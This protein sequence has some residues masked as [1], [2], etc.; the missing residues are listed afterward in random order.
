MAPQVFATRQVAVT[1]KDYESLGTSFASPLSGKVAVAKAF[2]TKT[3]MQDTDLE[4][5]LQNIEADADLMQT[6]VTTNTPTIT[7]NITDITTVKLTDITSQS[8][9][10]ALAVTAAQAAAVTSPA[11]DITIDYGKQ[12]SAIA[13][14]NT[15]ALANIPGYS[16]CHTSCG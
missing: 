14:V 10:I 9:N 6:S 7:S 12:A 15:S 13:I 16:W 5:I 1:K 3:A 11:D 4:A 2:V 8:G